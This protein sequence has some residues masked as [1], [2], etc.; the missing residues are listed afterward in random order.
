MNINRM[1]LILLSL[2]LVVGI[3]GCVKNFTHD[4]LSYKIKSNREIDL[5][6]A[7]DPHHLSKETYDD[8]PAFDTFLNTGDGKLLNYSGEIL[9]AFTMDIQNR[10]P[11]IV[12]FAGDLTCNGERESHLEL[13]EKLRTI[14]RSGTHVFVIPGNHDIEN[15]W[16]RNYIGD[17]LIR[18]DS[19]TSDEF[20]DIYSQFGYKDAISRDSDSLSYLATPSEDIWLL[21]LDSAKYDR[22]KVRDGP[23]M[24]GVLS[25]KTLNWIEQCGELAR[26][27]NAKLVAIMHHSLLDHSPIVNENY[28]IENNDEAIEVLQNSGIEIIL[29][30]HVHLQDIKSHD[31]GGNTIYDIATSCLIAHPNQYGTLRFVPGKGFYY[32]TNR[33]NMDNWAREND[34]SD[35]NLKDFHEYSRT[36]FQK[37][38]YDRYYDSLLEIGGYTDME[39]QAISETIAILNLGYFGGFRNDALHH[40]FNTDGFKLLIE[41]S[42]NFIRDYALSMFN[43]EK[44][45]NNKIF[46]PIN[47]NRDS[48]ETHSGFAN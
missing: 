46:I 32:Q 34:T 26:E 9:D 15:P 39:M 5:F 28:T 21:M 48:T 12:V 1:F 13:A 4:I 18:I 47:L 42:P 33:V 25:G 29:T 3:I 17:E 10:K 24:G 44:T 14:K 20:V 11:D 2:V 8:G 27:N 22:N 40:I 43:D 16:A 35:S 30:G 45:D 41:S 19:I 38:S 37:R 23:E 31:A 6:I 36:F 7:A